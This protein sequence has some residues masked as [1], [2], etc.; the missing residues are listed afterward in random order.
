LF[1]QAAKAM[2]GCG[3]PCY[4]V[5]WLGTTFC[6]RLSLL[7]P[8]LLNLVAAN[9]SSHSNKLFKSAKVNEAELKWVQH[10]V[11]QLSA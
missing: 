11:Q 1:H 7:E 2:Q 6:D 3:I 8:L 4:E 5:D 9:W 10:R